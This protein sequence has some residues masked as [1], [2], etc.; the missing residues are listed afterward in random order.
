MAAA[1]TASCPLLLSPLAPKQALPFHSAPGLFIMAMRLACPFRPYHPLSP[2]FN[3]PYPRKKT[4]LG[5]RPAAL[6]TRF[7][8]WLYGRRMR[9]RRRSNIGPPSSFLSRMGEAPA[10]AQHLGTRRRGEHESRPCC[11]PH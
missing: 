1:A 10:V 3:S 5:S 2:R 9:M 4:G 8:D 11:A 7:T 6:V